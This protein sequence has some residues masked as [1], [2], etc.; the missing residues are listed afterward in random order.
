MILR[1]AALSSL[2]EGKDLPS[3]PSRLTPL[4]EAFPRRVRDVP[5]PN[6]IVPSM[7]QDR[8]QA[9]LVSALKTLQRF[10][11]KEEMSR[12]SWVL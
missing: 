5:A 2:F 10:R 4:P 8:P 7:S 1:P 12:S 11:R 3:R 6:A 9:S